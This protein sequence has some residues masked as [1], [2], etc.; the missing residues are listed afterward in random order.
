MGAA[1]SRF[2]AET[3]NRRQNGG[4]PFNLPRGAI[5]A[6]AVVFIPGLA[7][8]EISGPARVVDGDTLEVA[9]ERIRLYG[10]DAPEKDQTCSIDARA[11]ACGIA[12]WGALVQITAG[13]M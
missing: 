11:W 7:L 4:F 12:A 6:L 2:N 1:G 10:I 13:R 8:A 5:F 3:P 9:G